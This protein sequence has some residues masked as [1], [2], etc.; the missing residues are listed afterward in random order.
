M[1]L[2]GELPAGAAGGRVPAPDGDGA[3]DVGEVGGLA[4]RLPAEAGGE[5]VGAVGA[6]Y[7]GEGAAG[8]IVAGVVGDWDIQRLCL[9]IDSCRDGEWV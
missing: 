7:L 9:V 8:N 6:G 4:E 5:A 1:A 2:V 3:A